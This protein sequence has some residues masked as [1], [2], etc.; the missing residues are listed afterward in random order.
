MKK[1]NRNHALTLS[2]LAAGCLLGGMTNEGAAAASPAPAETVVQDVRIKLGARGG[3]KT[4]RGAIGDQITISFTRAGEDLTFTGK[5]L[6]V[7]TA[8]RS[9]IIEVSNADGKKVFL[10]NDIRSITTEGPG[11]PSEDS[12]G[13]DTDATSANQAS[14]RRDPSVTSDQPQPSN[15]TSHAWGFPTE[16][17]NGNTNLPKVFLLPI[18]GGVGDGTRHNEMKRIGEIADQY[19]PGQIIVLRVNSP[20]G[21][22]AEADRISETLLDLG[23][24]HTLV[25]WVQSAISAAAYTSLHCRKI[26]FMKTGNLGSATM[27]AGQT[28]ISGQTLAAWVKKFGDIAE[29]HGH[30][31]ELVEAMITNGELCSYDPGDDENPPRIYGT[32]EGEVDLSNENQNLTIN[33][34]DAVACGFADGIADNE[35][36]L[37]A[38][39]GLP[40]WYETTDDGRKIHRDWQKTLKAANLE[41][42]SLGRKAQGQLGMTDDPVRNLSRR[43]DAVKKLIRWSKKLG[44]H[45]S[46]MVQLPPLE[47]LEGAKKNL[48]EE[49]RRARSQQ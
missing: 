26:Y 14:D 30:S 43:L 21:L 27:F 41:L 38:M 32:L 17:N 44:D 1:R 40:H 34:T 46:M 10:T 25:A 11:T 24:R 49:L 39:L 6:S 47:A 5:L 28:A 20:G 8:G 9:A 42:P 22:V 29:E 4:W 37:A 12:T 33:A 19:G 3:N 45:T 16:P 36:E 13:D 7:R 35:E 31:R 23:T 15:P 48:E 2:L 18:D